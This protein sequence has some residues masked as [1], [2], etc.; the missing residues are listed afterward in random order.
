MV[1]YRPD[2]NIEFIGRIDNQVKI[3][4]YR[5]ELGEIEALLSRHPQVREAVVIH[6]EDQPGDK[7]LVAYVVP[8][9]DKEDLVQED[10]ETSVELWPSVAEYYVYDELLYYA[11]TN[12]YRRNQ[13]Y[14]VAINQ[15][16][17]DKVVVEI[18][19][20]KDAI[21]ARLWALHN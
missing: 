16:V 11:M 14:Q 2:G 18:G 7:R 8:E 5:I 4:G 21:L 12:D 10:N 1:R 3:R 20:G 13:S 19:T 17:K 9:L 15:S 6:R